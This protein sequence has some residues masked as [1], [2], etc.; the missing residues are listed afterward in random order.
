MLDRAKILR[1]FEALNE[2]LEKQGEIGEICLCGGAVMCLVFDA[3]ES[4]KDVDAIF[5]PTK[6]IREA[7]AKVARE[8]GVPEDWL[9]DAA[10]GFFM[11][12]PSKVPVLDLSHL[13]VTAPSA[14]YML[15]MK[16]ISARFD[17]SDADDVRF[18]IKHLKL[19]ASTEVFHIVEK[20]YPRQQIPPKTQF[21]VEELLQN[22][23]DR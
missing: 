12:E 5:R 16:C 11:S 17:T 14:D 21:L 9:N 19:E 6:K 18:L 15:A 23:G 13:R 1:L 3:R 7:S 2:E 4:T 20:Y 10:K 22:S 8:L